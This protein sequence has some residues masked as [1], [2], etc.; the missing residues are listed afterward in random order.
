ML[1]NFSPRSFLFRVFYRICSVLQ[2]FGFSAVFRVQN[3]LPIFPNRYVF[4]LRRLHNLVV[5]VH[6]STGIE[7]RTGVL[8]FLARFSQFFPRLIFAFPTIASASDN[9]HN[10]A[11]C[12]PRLKLFYFLFFTEISFHISRMDSEMLKSD[13]PDVVVSLCSVMFTCCSRIFYSLV[14]GFACTHFVLRCYHCVLRFYFRCILIGRKIVVR[15][16]SSIQLFR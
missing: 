13:C 12:S 7:G 15:I 11:T 1:F 9:I 4:V 5:L 3:S 10:F 8:E 6:T 16:S 14:I 2:F